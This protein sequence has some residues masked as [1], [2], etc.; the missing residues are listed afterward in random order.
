MEDRRMAA[1]KSMSVANLMDLKGRVDAAIAEKMTARR[2][3][4]ELELSELER[5]DPKARRHGKLGPVAPKY[6]NSKDPSQT[7]AGRGL[8]PRWIREAIKSGK[9]LESF[10]IK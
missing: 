1:L 10:L 5:H 3:E 6:R 8:Q 9:K 7:W 2:K 4:L